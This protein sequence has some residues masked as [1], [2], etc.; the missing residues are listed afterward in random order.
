MM[1]GMFQALCMFYLLGHTHKRDPLRLVTAILREEL[2]GKR[3]LLLPF[4]LLYAF[5]F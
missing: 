3:A 2:Q 5:A 4:F 1:Q